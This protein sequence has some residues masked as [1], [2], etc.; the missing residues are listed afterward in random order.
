MHLQTLIERWLKRKKFNHGVEEIKLIEQYIESNQ[1]VRYDDIMIMME[2][3][4]KDTIIFKL[5]LLL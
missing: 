2:E 3:D 4:K 5:L 1:S